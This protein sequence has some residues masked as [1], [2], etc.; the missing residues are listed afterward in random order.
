[1][2]RIVLPGYGTATTFSPVEDTTV[3]VLANGK[4]IPVHLKAGQ[5]T[6][7]EFINSMELAA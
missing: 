6:H 2:R 7:V 1:M 5:V 4:L 3:T